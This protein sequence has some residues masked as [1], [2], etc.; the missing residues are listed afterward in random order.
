MNGVVNDSFLSYSSTDP[1]DPVTALKWGTHGIWFNLIMFSFILFV[2]SPLS[3]AI[4]VP[5]GVFMPAFALGASFGRCELL[6]K[7]L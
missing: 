7:L 6:I 3:V 5:G 1:I 4:P 2:F